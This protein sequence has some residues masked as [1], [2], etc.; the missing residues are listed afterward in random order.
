VLR[1]YNPGR[2]GG[3]RSGQLYNESLLSESQREC[4]DVILVRP[5]NPLNIGA[6][7][8][9]MANFG[10]TRLKVVAPYEAVWREARSAIGAQR[11]VRNATVS[12]TLAEALAPSTFAIATATLTCRRAEQPVVSLPKLMPY[13]EA[14]LQRGGRL[15]I[16]FG[17]EKRGLTRDDLSRCHLVV[18]IP[19]D[20]QQPSMNLGQAVAV[21]LY[22]L[23]RLS[24]KERAPRPE[25]QATETHADSGTLE[26]LA[27]VID[28]TM[29]A[30]GYS[31]R[32]TEAANRHDLHLFLRRLRLLPADARRALGFFRRVQWR[33]EHPHR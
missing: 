16:V 30:A 27:E 5:R 13:V 21:C 19:T 24:A 22:E 33:L 6:A 32:I 20:A 9:A 10:F 1:V 31:K 4:F 11:Q 14:E 8:R 18:E 26:R 23:A 12:S 2:I 15:A 25:G 29:S 7:A 3:L 28:H 17:S